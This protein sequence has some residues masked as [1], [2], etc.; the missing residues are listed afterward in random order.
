[1]SPQALTRH[2][3]FAVNSL[4][5]GEVEGRRFRRKIDASQPIGR[6]ESHMQSHLAYVGKLVA[7]IHRLLASGKDKCV[8][9]SGLDSGRR[10]DNC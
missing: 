4:V 5:L 9:F 7:N 8:G 10:N 2:T 6:T 1:M 3:L